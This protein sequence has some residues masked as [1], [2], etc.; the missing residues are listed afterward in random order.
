MYANMIPIG[1]SPFLPFVLDYN[2][3]FTSHNSHKPS[4][5]FFS[6]LLVV[7]NVSMGSIGRLLCALPSHLSTEFGQSGDSRR[8]LECHAQDELTNL[9]RDGTNLT[10][11]SHQISMTRSSAQAAGQPSD[12]ERRKTRHCIRVFMC[13]GMSQA[14]I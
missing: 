14:P 11:R 9:S 1:I 10:C 4:I 7:L 8:G 3:L 2:T 13:F 6:S 5:P 12:S